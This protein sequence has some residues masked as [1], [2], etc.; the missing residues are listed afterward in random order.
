[1]FAFLRRLREVRFMNVMFVKV[2]L[3]AYPKLRAIARSVSAAVENQAV[4]S[5]RSKESALVT[6]E[7]IV[8]EMMLQCNLEHVAEALDRVLERLSEEELFFLEYKYFRRNSLLKGKFSGYAPKCCERSYYRKQGA[9]LQ[10]VHF[11]SAAQGWTEDRFFEAFGEFSYFMKLYRAL[12]N[13]KEQAIS[14]RRKKSGIGF[15]KSACSSE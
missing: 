7:K 8:K 4:L 3:Y 9:L 2:L 11:L 6:A 10:K 14:V 1:M 12:Q 5:F 15:Q 13:G